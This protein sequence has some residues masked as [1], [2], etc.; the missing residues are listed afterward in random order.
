MTVQL[1]YG[2][3][4][5]R[6]V[7]GM[8]AEGPDQARHI[9]SGI[10]TGVLEPG[11][12]VTKVSG[13]DHAYEPINAAADLLQAASPGVVV[14]SPG[15]IPSLASGDHLYE[16]EDA[17]PIMKRGKCYMVTETALTKGARPF[18]RFTAAGAEKAGALRNNADTAD[19]VAVPWLIVDETVTGPGLVRV[20]VNVD[21]AAT[22]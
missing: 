9:E 6:A 3:D 12:V 1:T 15:Q 11:L 10:A 16:D 4:A 14:W 2:T 18:V 13:S 7:A 22:A 8:I 21:L 20:R 19:A 5:P 17:F